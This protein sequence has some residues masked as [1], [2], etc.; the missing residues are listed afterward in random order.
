MTPWI[1]RIESHLG[2]PLPADLRELYEQ[3]DGESPHDFVPYSTS[4][5]MRLMSADE[6]IENYGRSRLFG[7]DRGWCMFWASGN[8]EYAA[9]YLTGPLTGRV[10]I[11]D[12]D[13]RHDSIAFRSV[14]SFVASMNDLA[15]GDPGH[16]DWPYLAT[17]YYVDSEYF[18]RGKATCKP[19]TAEEIAAD[20]EA[21]KQLRA[22]YATAQ[23][24]DEL[25]EH[26][27]AFNIMALTPT[28]QTESIL[29]FLEP[30]DSR[31]MWIQERACNLLGHRRFHPATAR[32]GEVVRTGDTN[33]RMAALRAL[34]R[35]REHH[36]RGHPDHDA[37]AHRKRHPAPDHGRTFQ[38]YHSV[39]RDQ[40]RQ[41]SRSRTAAG[42]SPISTVARTRMSKRRP[43][44]SVPV[45]AIAMPL[46]RPSASSASSSVAW[47]TWAPVAT[48]VT[49]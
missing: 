12:N 34:G 42:T 47:L 36:E 49:R 28:N 10:Y 3:G 21:Q 39:V 45:S 16:N 9:A 43:S 19:A 48:S 6:V 41:N 18:Y 25:D 13:G 35:D 40:L 22:E 27:Y 33:G 29:E 15:A 1:E 17:D 30:L 8:G 7:P 2:V 24:N 32:L 37:R 14:R 23:I 20:V 11:Y 46:M 4:R 26:H 5:A 44:G 31:D 38:A